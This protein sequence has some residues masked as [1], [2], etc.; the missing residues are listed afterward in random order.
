[1]G[2]IVETWKAR[3]VEAARA[4]L[5]LVFPRH[6]VGCGGPVEDEVYAFMCAPCRADLYF[7]DGAYCRAC[8]YP[9]LGMST[10]DRVCPNC[11]ELRPVFERGRALLLHRGLG[12][13]LIIELKYR[14]GLFLRNDLARL[15]RRF[16]DLE[17]Y[18]GDAVLVPVPLHP[19]KERE[20]GFNQSRVLAELF[21][22]T[23]E[24]AAVEDALVRTR[25]TDSQTRLRREERAGNVKNAF[26]IAPGY[27]IREKK[28]FIVIDDVYTTGSTLDACARALLD[29]GAGSVRVL[30][31]AHG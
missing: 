26:A 28:N 12:G 8:G 21:A 25:D 31:L 4:G 10:A 1:M 27:A 23:A 17:V 20:R 18:I 9:Y 29:G 22:A 6:C 7:I 15:I 24:G 2:S 16:A 3:A 19:R 11:R 13:R 5:D 30:A 14:R